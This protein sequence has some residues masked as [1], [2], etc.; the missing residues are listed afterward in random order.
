[1]CSTTTILKNETPLLLIHT[2]SMPLVLIS[3]PSCEA[4]SNLL[5]ILIISNG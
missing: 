2:P 1:M 4:T 3:I 5:I